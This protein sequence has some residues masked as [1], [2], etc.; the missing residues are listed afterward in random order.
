MIQIIKLMV[1]VSGN[2]FVTNDNGWQKS[3]IKHVTIEMDGK[4][5]TLLQMTMTF[6]IFFG[7]F[8]LLFIIFVPLSAS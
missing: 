5:G 6:W 2:R 4:K 7:V 3:P 8:I 1:H